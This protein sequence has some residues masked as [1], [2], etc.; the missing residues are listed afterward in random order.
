MDVP[1]SLPARVYLTAYDTQ[2]KKLTR[3]SRLHHLVRTAALEE[4]TLRGL[5]ADRDGTVVVAGHRTTGDPVLDDVLSRIRGSK[6]R[7]WKHWVGKQGTK[8]R[9]ALR[10][11]LAA[12][13]VIRV[14][15][16]RIL[17]LIPH[18]DV[19]LRDGRAAKELQATAARALTG[20]TP[21]PRLDPRVVSLAAIAA[22]GE[23]DT[24]CKGSVRR[25]NRNRIKEL[26]ALSGPAVPALKKVLA[27]EAGAAV[28]A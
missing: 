8:T 16:R 10:D 7:N 9:N 14:E 24:V 13:R 21:T 1:R 19:T 6:P 4:L 2:R 12:E 23:L 27:D 18:S 22:I 11:Q 5:I 17:G 20:A 26:I 15:R 28:A 3:T 25:E